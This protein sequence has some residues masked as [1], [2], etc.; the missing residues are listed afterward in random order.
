M[1][2]NQAGILLNVVVLAVVISEVGKL[3]GLAS[4]VVLFQDGH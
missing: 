1:E 4:A 3:I 2:G